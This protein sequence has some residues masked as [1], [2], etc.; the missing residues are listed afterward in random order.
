M[1]RF[2]LGSIAAANPA[3]SRLNRKNNY[4]LVHTSMYCFTDSCTAMYLH[5]LFL[6][7]SCT[8]LY[9]LVPPCTMTVQDST[10]WY[11]PV[12]KDL[13]IF[14]VSTYWY[15]P[16]EVS[17][18]AMSPE[19]YVPGC[20]STYFLVQPYTRCTGFQMNASCTVMVR[21]IVRDHDTCRLMLPP[22]VSAQSAF[23]LKLKP[24]ES[25]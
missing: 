9:H 7:Q 18:T 12:R 8:T 5:V 2:W 14:Y 23:E 11:I 20:T 17:R 6:V 1:Q 3:G 10:Y 13:G 15:V 21:V 22:P 19:A 25:A 16:F 24:N 4:V